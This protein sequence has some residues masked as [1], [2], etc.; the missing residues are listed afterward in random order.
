MIHDLPFVVLFLSVDVPEAKD[1]E[2]PLEVGTFAW[3][4]MEPPL[5]QAS[6]FLLCMQYARAQMQNLGIKPYTEYFRHP[7]DHQV[8]AVQ[9]L[10]AAVLLRGRPPQPRSQHG[11]TRPRCHVA[12]CVRCV[13]EGAV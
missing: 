1:L 3:N 8:P 7:P 13:S 11:L 10:R 12:G 6:F 5:G 4:W 9:P 2:T